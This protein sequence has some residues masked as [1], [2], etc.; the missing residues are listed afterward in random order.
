MYSSFQEY[1]DYFSKKGGLTDCMHS[2]DCIIEYIDIKVCLWKTDD[3][4]E[5]IQHHVK[6]L[7]EMFLNIQLL[8]LQLQKSSSPDYAVP[9]DNLGKAI[10]LLNMDEIFSKNYQI[11]H[12]FKYLELIKTRE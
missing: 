9:Y 5:H 10:E 11:K 2:S 8:I 1:D 3:L 6:Q 7:L 4:H 12:S